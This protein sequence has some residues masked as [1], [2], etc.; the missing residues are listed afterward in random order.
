MHS[1][2]WHRGICI[3]YRSVAGLLSFVLNASTCFSILEVCDDLT[4]ATSTLICTRRVG[5]VEVALFIAL[6]LT[7]DSSSQSRLCCACFWFG[8]RHIN[9]FKPRRLKSILLL[10]LVLIDVYS[11]SWHRW[12]CNVYRFVADLYILCSS[13]R[14]CTR[15]SALF[16]YVE[17]I[18]LL[19]EKKC[20]KHFS[21]QPD[22]CVKICP[23]FQIPTFWL[24]SH[25]DLDWFLLS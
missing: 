3:V 5:V 9:Y 19:L 25:L 11:W 21:S 14:V 2:S 18:N 12:S 22:K 13:T 15:I 7:S 8:D 16:N 24:V 1:S 6:L 4:S 10:L 23:K 20:Q 17:S